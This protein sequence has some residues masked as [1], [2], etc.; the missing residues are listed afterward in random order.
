MSSDPADLSEMIRRS[1][2][3]H[4]GYSWDTHDGSTVLLYMVTWIPSIYP[5]YVSNIYIYIYIYHTWI[6]HGYE[7]DHFWKTRYPLVMADIAI[8]HGPF[9]VDLPIKNGDFL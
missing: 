9:I 8:E 1:P 6:R 7:N 3:I 2:K 5:L 4:G